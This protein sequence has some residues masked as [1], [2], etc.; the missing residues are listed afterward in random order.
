MLA[1]L[2]GLLKASIAAVV[3][4]GA[5]ILWHYFGKPWI[6]RRLVE[7]HKNVIHELQGVCPGCGGEL[8]ILHK[9]IDRNHGTESAKC[10]GECNKVHT[11][12]K[13]TSLPHPFLPM[14]ES[15]RDICY[16]KFKKA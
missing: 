6:Q 3:I 14:L 2:F 13:F 5:P 7:K 8:R 9:V 12:Y 16:G 1:G 4:C 11:D 10:I 15:K